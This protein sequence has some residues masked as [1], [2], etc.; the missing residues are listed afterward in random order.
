MALQPLICCKVI[1][2]AG[3]VTSSQAALGHR[4]DINRKWLCRIFSFCCSL[5]PASTSS[6]QCVVSLLYTTAVNWPFFA[7]EESCWDAPPPP[8]PPSMNARRQTQACSPPA[9]YRSHSHLLF[10]LAQ[11]GFSLICACDVLQ[12]MG[13][14]T[15]TEPHLY[16]ARVNV[17]WRNVCVQYVQDVSLASYQCGNRE[18]V[19]SY[20]LCL[21]W[22][23]TFYQHR[24]LK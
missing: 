13:A 8:T 18:E 9:S 24:Q 14:A 2:A 3:L 21:S 22:R 6:C 17:I 16:E 12:R 4:V 19:A 7:A 10:Y 11:Q 1:S 5:H 20:M 23:G 15:G